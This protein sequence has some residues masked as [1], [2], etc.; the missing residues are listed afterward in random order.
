M[1]LSL[2]E[3]RTFSLRNDDVRKNCQVFIQTVLYSGTSKKTY[4]ETRFRLYNKQKT[5]NSIPLPPDPL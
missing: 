2:L 3:F 1:Y 5:K 4:V